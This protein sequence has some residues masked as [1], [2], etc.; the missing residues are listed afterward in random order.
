MA[1][2][3]AGLSYPSF[4]ST[5]VGHERQK[6]LTVDERVIY[7]DYRAITMIRC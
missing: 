1:V 6:M 5:S 7:G 4:K 3:I 2:F